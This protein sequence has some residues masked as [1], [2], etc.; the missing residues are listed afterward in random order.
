MKLT[1][2][3]SLL[4]SLN[5][6]AADNFV[7]R[8]VSHAG[9][10]PHPQTITAD[11]HRTGLV[12]Y[13]VNDLK[14]KKTITTTVAVLAPAQVRKLLAA[15]SKLSAASLKDLD[16]D[17]PRCMDAPSRGI[18]VLD[19]TGTPFQISSWHACHRYEIPDS[20]EAQLITN[21]LGALVNL[22]ETASRR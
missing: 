2:L 11:I 21:V 7:A 22:A 16:A 3:F 13:K 9:F 8:Y 10:S 6:H 4:L 12:T 19:K 5:V 18:S 1:L 17:K 14:T 15:A 20:T